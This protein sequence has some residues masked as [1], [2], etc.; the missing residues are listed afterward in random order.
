MNGNFKAAGTGRDG[1]SEA[2]AERDGERRTGYKSPIHHKRGR[3]FAPMS[4]SRASPVLRAAAACILVFLVATA[5]ASP[6]QQ[7]RL[8]FQV[9]EGRVLNYFLREGPV[10]AHLVLRS[11][12]E[13]RILVVFPAGN[14]GVGLWFARQAGGAAWKIRGEPQPVHERDERGR[15]LYGISAEVTLAVPE[16]DVHG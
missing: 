7:S 1:S 14:S 2:A 3:T 12:P 4:H 16:L 9:R 6:A 10:A 5:S 8:A 15:A 11:G 13:P